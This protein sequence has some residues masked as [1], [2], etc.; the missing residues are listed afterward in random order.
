V[1]GARDG[2]DRSVV[3][4][5]SQRFS[6]RPSPGDQGLRRLSSITATYSACRLMPAAM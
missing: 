1:D 3:V 4:G 5:R 2:L 6:P